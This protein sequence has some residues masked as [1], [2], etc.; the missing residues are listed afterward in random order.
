MGWQEPGEGLRPPPATD[1]V[2]MRS[3]I[4]GTAEIA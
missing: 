2:N 4:G 1:G 3:M